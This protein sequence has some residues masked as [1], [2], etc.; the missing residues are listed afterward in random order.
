M[1]IE[2]ST[3]GKRYHTKT[4]KKKHEIE[5]S[6]G[7]K[8]AV[9][10]WLSYRQ[11]VT[12]PG[13]VECSVCKREYDLSK[14][15]NNTEIACICGNLLAVKFPDE[16]DTSP[17][18]RKTD[19]MSKQLQAKLHG[20]IDTC[21][22]IHF[23]RDIDKL[24]LLIVRVTTEML[25]AEGCSIILHDKDNHDLVF[26]SVTGSKSST[27]EQF[28]LAEG[29]GVAGN[30]IRSREPLVVNNVEMD[31]RFSK[32]A[33]ETSGFSTRNILCT[34]L[35][36]EGDCIG[37][38]ELVN[39]QK[40]EEFNE[41]DLFLGEA[42]SNQ[43]AIAIHNVQLT[44][45]ALKAER[46]AAIGQA[47]TGVAH[48]VKNMLSGLDGGLYVLESDIEEKYG[49]IPERGYEMLGRNIQRL[50]D[51][52]QDMLTY[53]KDRM[54]EYSLTNLNE[55][56]ESIVDLMKTKANERKVELTFKPDETI[57]DI[58]IDPKG[59]YRCVLNLV[60]N[61]IDACETEGA[62]VTLHTRTSDSKFIVVEVEDQGSGMDEKT[63]QSIF[64]PFFSNKGS[65]GTG[66]GLS[67]TQ[68]IVQEHGGKIEV[69]S[70]PG[71]GST[72][73]IYL[74]IKK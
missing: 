46:L 8:L 14:Y 73:T 21:R 47:V 16:H 41:E 28:R 23:I 49:K 2:C 72:F 24:L 60:S 67:V 17:G 10:P 50:K 52:V 3:C 31:S 40:E 53:S 4:S 61:A 5:C 7:E 27:L 12:Q 11:S 39:K 25:D 54:P 48:C 62:S 36:V 64:Q 44:E 74:P 58:V 55:L 29:E 45:A 18:R 51:L 43:I 65:K 38:L 15:R 20:L 35:I 1:F 30:V 56:I 34:P 70:V 59:I 37:A 19:H 33:D 69:D 22:L 6:C 9:L 32:R 68:K 63:L 26:H 66:L 71:K 57:D 13:T 42:V